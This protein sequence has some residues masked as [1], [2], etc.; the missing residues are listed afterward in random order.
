MMF[1][2]LSPDCVVCGDGVL[3]GFE[4]C[5]D[6]NR[7]NFDGCNSGCRVEDKSSCDTSVDPNVCTCAPS[8][9]SVFGNS[10][11]NFTELKFSVGSTIFSAD[12]NK[13]TENLTCADIFEEYSSLGSNSSC[14]IAFSTLE[15]TISEDNTIDWESPLTLNPGFLAREGCDLTTDIL[16]FR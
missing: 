1:P 3:K 7:N 12:P 15:I 5:E 16:E 13:P 11:N 14:E 2:G 8:M 9:A 4:T 10:Y 6:G